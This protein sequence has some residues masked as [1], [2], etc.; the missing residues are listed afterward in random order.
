MP[1][2]LMFWGTSSHAL[3]FFKLQKR[4]IRLIKGCGYS[5]VDNT[6]GIY[7]LKNTVYTLIDD[8]CIKTD[9]YEYMI[10]IRI[11]MEYKLDKI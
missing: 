7:C 5:H 3:R 4:V 9:K 2:G 11:A 8:V 10:Q 1:Y 6:L